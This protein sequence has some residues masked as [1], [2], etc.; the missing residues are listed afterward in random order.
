LKE[1]EF[2]IDHCDAAAPYPWKFKSV[3]DIQATRWLQ[4][5]EIQ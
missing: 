1:R 3:L 2:M 4:W 5:P